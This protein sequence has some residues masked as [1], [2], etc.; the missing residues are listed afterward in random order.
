MNQLD[1]KEFKNLL[2]SKLP[3]PR[4]NQWFTRKVV[5][6]LPE[7]SQSRFIWVEIV[8]YC[9]CGLLCGWFWVKFAT[10]ININVITLGEIVKYIVLLSVT[11]VVLWQALRRLWL[12][13]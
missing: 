4:K 5:N 2:N 1:D 9:L 10:N 6:K 11:G 3:E 12:T 13:D 7:N 8:S